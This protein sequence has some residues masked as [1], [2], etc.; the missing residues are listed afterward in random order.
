[1]P[2][3]CS[4]YRLTA[5]QRFCSLSCTL[6]YT[7]MNSH[8]HYSLNVFF[9]T[10]QIPPT[11]NT[12]VTIANAMIQKLDTDD[13]NVGKIWVFYETYFS[14]DGF[15]NKTNWSKYWIHVKVQKRKI[16]NKK[17]LNLSLAFFVRMG[18]RWRN[19]RGNVTMKDW[20]WLGPM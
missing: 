18:G 8:T 2:R 13:F 16:C 12:C 5:C 19:N 3:S 6:H 17:T 10:I 1:M 7:T 9:Y 15:V 4:P 11:I 14:L 20:L